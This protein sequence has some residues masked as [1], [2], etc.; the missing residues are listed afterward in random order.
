MAIRGGSVLEIDAILMGARWRSEEFIDF[1]LSR[2][3]ISCMLILR[4]SPK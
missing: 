1:L 2:Q 4:P 3:L